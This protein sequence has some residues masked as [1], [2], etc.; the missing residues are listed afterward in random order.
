MN[1]G[2]KG[3]S[4]PVV[5]PAGQ[6]LTGLV[7]FLFV[8]KIIGFYIPD[9]VLDS[10]GEM[11]VTQRAPASQAH[12]Q[13]IHAVGQQ[14]DSESGSQL[15]G[16]RRQSGSPAKATLR[17]LQH[18]ASVQ[19]F[20]DYEEAG[21]QRHYGP[22]DTAHYGD[23]RAT[24]TEAHQEN[25]QHADRARGG[26]QLPPQARGHQKNSCSDDNASERRL[27]SARQ[28]SIRRNIINMIF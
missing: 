23:R 22:G 27:T 24:I 16:K 2:I 25:R 5:R 6:L 10:A 20:D 7:L 17:D 21:D 9:I 28:G 1:G 3:P 19:C 14:G 11:G 15:A 13:I 4:G 26:S 8:G 12:G 18:A